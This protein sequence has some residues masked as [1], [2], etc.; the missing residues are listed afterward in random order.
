MEYYS[1]VSS[2][3]MLRFDAAPPIAMADFVLRCHDW[4]SPKDRE[5][6]DAVT[7]APDESAG[8]P[9]DSLAAR[10]LVWET[11]LRNTLSQRRQSDLKLPPGNWQRPAA[12]L[13]ADLPESVGKILQGVNPLD[14]ARE[15]DR[16]RWNRL[17]DLAALHTFDIEALCA[18]KLKL[19]I[20]EKWR[21]R[22][23]AAG[24]EEFAALVNDIEKQYMERQ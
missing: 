21:P 6:F 1:L 19:A 3:P 16:L 24:R 13:V 4:L 23:A 20:L 8:L 7:L 5:L 14:N 9:P 22:Q 10:F 12:D 11:Q 18:Y 15:F 17:E 2:L